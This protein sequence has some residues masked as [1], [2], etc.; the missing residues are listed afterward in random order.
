MNPTARR[1]LE[2]KE[3]NLSD[4]LEQMT[5]S[6]FDE[7]CKKL[8]SFI[9]LFPQKETT[10]KEVFS[11][12][13][14][15]LFISTITEIQS[16]L[17]DIHASEH[18][19]KSIKLITDIK[20]S[21]RTTTEANMTFFLT[22][23]SSLSIDIQMALSNAS[24]AVKRV[25]QEQPKQKCVLAVDDVPL[26]LDNIKVIVSGAGYKFIGMTSPFAALNLL[27]MQRPDLFILDVEMPQMT[28]YELAEKIRELGHTAPIVFLTGNSSKEYV[29][30]AIQAGAADFI[31]KPIIYEHV[32]KK[33]KKFIGD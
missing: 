30:K 22:E 28:G 32:Q 4:K 29:I 19:Q 7:Y 10:L 27:T 23:V 13:N 15:R 25:R 31:V 8:D 6:Q 11:I 21:N 1:L 33:I 9:E 18:A 17:S 14:D 12:W 24:A 3:L 2:I 16:M 5:E 26:M 20:M